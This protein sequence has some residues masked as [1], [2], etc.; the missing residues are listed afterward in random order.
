MIGL[1]IMKSVDVDMYEYMYLSLYDDY[2]IMFF[3][4]T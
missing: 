2:M 4:L 3:V 1:I